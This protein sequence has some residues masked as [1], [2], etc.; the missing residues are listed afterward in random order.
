M[1]Y[2]AVSVYGVDENNER[3]YGVH[4]IRADSEKIALEIRERHHISHPW[5]AIPKDT[6]YIRIKRLRSNKWN[7]EM[8][9]RRRQGINGSIWYEDKE[10]NLQKESKVTSN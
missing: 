3:V 4:I 10:G 2:F 5:G 1:K 6:F 9:K 8:L 7:K